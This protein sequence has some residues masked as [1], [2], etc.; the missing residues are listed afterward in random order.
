MFS[1]QVPPNESSPSLHQ[2]VPQCATPLFSY[3]P[4]FSLDPSSSLSSFNL[5]TLISIVQSHDMERTMKILTKQID[6]V[7][8]KST[9]S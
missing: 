3:K 9:T 4:N 8:E 6:I 2:S 5:C 7:K 1:L